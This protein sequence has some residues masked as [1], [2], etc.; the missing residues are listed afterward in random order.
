MQPC[1]ILREDSNIL[2]A[3]ARRAAK[4][5]AA[6]DLDIVKIVSIFLLDII[7]IVQPRVLR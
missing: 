5:I 1:T 7:W 3:A 4:Q 6:S 2:D